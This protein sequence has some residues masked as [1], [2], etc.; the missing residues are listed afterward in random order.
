MFFV[1]CS[2]FRWRLGLV[3]DHLRTGIP[4][5]YVSSHP[6]QLS[7]AIPPWVGAM[8]TSES[9]RVNRNTARYT[10]PISMVSQSELVSVWLRAK[11]TEISAD[12]WANWLGKDFTLS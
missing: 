7:L 6:G 3:G 4:S 2:S 9:R 8:S 5:H 12:L 11:E 10:S 1:L